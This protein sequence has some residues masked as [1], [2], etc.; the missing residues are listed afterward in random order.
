MKEQPRNAAAIL[1]TLLVVGAS[2]LWVF[3]P[4]KPFPD[5]TGRGLWRA[6]RSASSIQSVDIFELY[7]AYQRNPIS[8]DARW[9]GKT[10]TLEGMVFGIGR[11]SSTNK[12]FINLGYDEYPYR[13]GRY[14]YARYI[15]A[16]C[17]LTREPESSLSSLV[18]DDEIKI[19][20]VISGVAPSGRVVV[21]DCKYIGKVSSK[22]VSL[23][24][25]ESTED[26]Q[27]MP[28]GSR[29]DGAPQ[30][31]PWPDPIVPIQ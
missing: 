23:Y 8:A 22:P 12:S 15:Y 5:S 18:I 20:G 27:Y 11:D 26:L 30:S 14:G 28:P 16:D 19:S 25:D 2:F 9:K 31:G 10:V 1:L 3:H 21:V 24:E 6:R 7:G 17:Y 13:Y 29:P 4:W